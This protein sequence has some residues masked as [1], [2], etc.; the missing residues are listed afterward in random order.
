MLSNVSPQAYANAAENEI[1]VR[2][3]EA[4]TEEEKT[5]RHQVAGKSRKK[6]IMGPMIGLVVILC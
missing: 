4:Q 1:E 2:V 5:S 6:L 3:R